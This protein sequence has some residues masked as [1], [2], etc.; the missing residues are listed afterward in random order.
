MRFPE[1]SSSSTSP[2]FSCHRADK[3]GFIIAHDDSGVGA[4]D[5]KAPGG[6]IQLTR[7]SLVHFFPPANQRSLFGFAYRHLMLI[8]Y[9]WSQGLGV[10][11]KC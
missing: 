11:R 5:E 9:L 10:N 3:R 8:S 1:R 4:A 6:E 2:R 7:L